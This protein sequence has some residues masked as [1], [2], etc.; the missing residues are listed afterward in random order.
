MTNWIYKLLGIDP[1][2]DVLR[3][4]RIFFVQPWPT[5]LAVLLG[6][7]LLAWVVFFYLRDGT[8]PSWLWKGLMTAFRVA[9]VAVLALMLWQPML[10]SQ[11]IQSTPSVV[12]VL[13]DESKSMAI[14]DRWQDAKRKADLVRA[15]EDPKATSATRAEMTPSVSSRWIRFQQGVGDRP[16]A[17]E[18]W[19]SES[20]ASTCS[21]AMMRRSMQSSPLPFLTMTPVA[22]RG[23]DHSPRCPGLLILHRYNRVSTQALSGPGAAVLSKPVSV[24]E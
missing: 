11:R 8:R 12:A 10:R 6:L 2:Q 18:I 1:G 23:C 22:R 9:A 20:V 13:V 14:R 16:T 5:V 15:L 3:A 24:V 4:D 19:A 21:R 17:W 7:A